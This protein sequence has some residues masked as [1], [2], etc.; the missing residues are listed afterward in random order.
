MVQ[1]ARLDE[2][3]LCIAPELAREGVRASTVQPVTRILTAIVLTLPP[4]LE[5]ATKGGTRVPHRSQSRYMPAPLPCQTWAMRV[6]RARALRAAPVT[7]LSSLLVGSFELKRRIENVDGTRFT[8]TGTAH[9]VASRAQEICYREEGVLVGEGTEYEVTRSYRYELT[10][11]STADLYLSDGSFFHHL[12]LAPG[13]C[14]AIHRC[15][16]DLYR[17]LYVADGDD[18]LI[19]WRCQGPHKDYVSTSRLTRMAANFHTAR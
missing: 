8:L 17:G 19:R 3:K 15:G 18:L 11:S 16:D 1:I 2:F 14:A 7:N 6:L 4:V 10:G 12:D 9:F 13:R 5:V